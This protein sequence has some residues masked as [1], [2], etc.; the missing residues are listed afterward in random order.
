MKN[1][2]QK[3]KGRQPLTEEEKNQRKEYLKTEGI[4]QRTKRVLNPRIIKTLIAFDS[5]IESI[6]SPRYRL[7]EE[8]KNKLY[9]VFSQRLDSLQNVLSKTK[10]NKE[11]MEE[12]L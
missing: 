4:E 11:E 2:N 7:D 5:I 12:V 1:K 9:A 3:Q 8:Q 6:D 10:T